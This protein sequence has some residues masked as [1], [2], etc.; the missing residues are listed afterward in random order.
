MKR[1]W[2]VLGVGSMRLPGRPF[3]FNAVGSMG[4]VDMEASINPTSEARRN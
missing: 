2:Y 3:S 4:A 1:K